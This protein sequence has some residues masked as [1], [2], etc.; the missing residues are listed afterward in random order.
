MLGESLLAM[1]LSVLSACAGVDTS[2]MR[3]YR[4]DSG[5]LASHQVRVFDFEA[6]PTHA[7]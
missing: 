2:I 4:R 7:L 6:P 5:H 3:F 1:F